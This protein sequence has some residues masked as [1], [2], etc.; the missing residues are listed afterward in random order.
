MKD[1]PIQ[2]TM[3]RHDGPKP[4]FAPAFVAFCPRSGSTW[5]RKLLNAHPDV[6]CGPEFSFFCN[7][8]GLGGQ[9]RAYLDPQSHVGLR[10]A[11]SPP[12]YFSHLNQHLNAIYAASVSE[13][14]PGATIV[15]D[16]SSSNATALD[17][18]PRIY[19]TSKIIVL[20]RDPADTVRSLIRASLSWNPDFPNT[21]ETAF[22]FW[23]AHM[24]KILQHVGAFSDVHWIHYDDL[25][26]SPQ[27]E[28]RACLRF[29]NAADLP[30]D[31]ID[32]ICD[33]ASLNSLKNLDWH[34]G[35]FFGHRPEATSESEQK[36]ASIDTPQSTLH[37]YVQL[38]D[39][40]RSARQKMVEQ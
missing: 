40:S 17:L 12:R 2:P 5:L 27:S 8:V 19:P 10:T 21:P 28:L 25:K 24:S 29:L 9:M 20:I 36:L 13:H 33:A 32:E 1:Q 18:I 22:E 35:K 16:K 11:L 31:N 4:P 34:D 6:S 23:E 7:K 30:S 37:L 38:T 26:A 14:K 3:P 39:L 15:V